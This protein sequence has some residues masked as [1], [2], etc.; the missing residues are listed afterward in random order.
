MLGIDLKSDVIHWCQSV[1]AELSYTGMTFVCDNVSNTPSNITPH[2][3]ISL[4]AC[5]VATDIVIDRA[6]ELGAKIILSTPCCHKY[7]NDKLN[8]PSLSFVSEHPHLKNKLC[9]AL[10]DSIRLARL[11]AFGYNASALELT[12]PEDTP[13]NTLIR[14]TLDEKLKDEELQKR[15]KQYEN[16]LDFVL[17]ENKKDYLKEI[18]SK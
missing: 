6:I 7:L 2:M 3:V 13:K 17:G 14:A 9:E 4:H 11:R 10:T 18:K 1:A 15:K 5:D 16:I 8:A 12:D